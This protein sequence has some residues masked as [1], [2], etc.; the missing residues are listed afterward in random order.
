MKVSTLSAA[1]ENGQQAHV[2]FLLG[3]AR[4]LQPA[5]QI[6][7]MDGVFWS[8]HTGTPGLYFDRT[9]RMHE[10]YSWIKDVGLLDRRVWQSEASK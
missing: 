8:A 2:P 1:A 9:V 6:L 3:C 5:I 4:P 10:F 7:S